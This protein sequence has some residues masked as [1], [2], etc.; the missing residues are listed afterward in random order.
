MSQTD[1]DSQDV[2]QD[3][4]SRT[5]S[6]LAC[7]RP[8]TEGGSPASPICVTAWH[9]ECI[10]PG[11]AAY[12]G[13]LPHAGSGVGGQHAGFSPWCW[14]WGLVWCPPC[15]RNEACFFLLRR[16]KNTQ[17]IEFLWPRT[18]HDSVSVCITLC[19]ISPPQSSCQ[20]LLPPSAL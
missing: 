7:R 6:P 11:R 12:W 18:G 3:R 14:W 16:D 2:Y 13:P 17:A 20:L 4:L 5:D 19:N 10:T 9:S 1:S 15:L 8:L